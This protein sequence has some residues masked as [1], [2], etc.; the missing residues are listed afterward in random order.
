MV[1]NCLAFFDLWL[2][3][4]FF[5]FF[6]FLYIADWI[7]LP[8]P[9]NLPDIVCVLFFRKAQLVLSASRSAAAH[10]SVSPSDN[11]IYTQ[12][13]RHLGS[14]R[15]SGDTPRPGLQSRV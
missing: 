1:P 5:Y 2:R 15:G 14:V 13:L 3:L 11:Y 9:C 6:F 8:L 4:P 12:L 7:P 10:L